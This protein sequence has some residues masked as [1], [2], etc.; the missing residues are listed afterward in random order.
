MDGF[1]T[2]KVIR[3]MFED[4]VRPTII[5]VTASESPEESMKCLS[6]GMGTFV[7]QIAIRHCRTDD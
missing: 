6:L 7:F 2:T 1:Q 3:A 4:S 5:S